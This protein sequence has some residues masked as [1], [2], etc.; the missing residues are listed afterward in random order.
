[1]RWIPN[2]PRLVVKGLSVRFLGLFVSILLAVVQQAALETFT[3]PGREDGAE[4][5]KPPA[6]RSTDCDAPLM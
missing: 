3:V 1:M 5:V 4:V 6:M 2:S